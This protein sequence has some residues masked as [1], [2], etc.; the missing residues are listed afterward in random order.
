MCV[1]AY[2]LVSVCVGWPGIPSLRHGWREIDQAANWPLLVHVCGSPVRYGYL[3]LINKH[4]SKQAVGLLCI[5]IV[6][7]L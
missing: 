6:Y 7:L 3:S 5:L 2:S 4:N 1:G